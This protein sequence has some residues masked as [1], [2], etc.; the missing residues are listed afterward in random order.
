MTYRKVFR[1]PKMAKG[2]RVLIEFE[3]A[4][5]AAEVFVN[6]RSVVLSEDG[7]TAFGADI[8]SFLVEGQNTIEV[9]TDNDWGYRQRSTNSHY[10][11]NNKNFNVNYGG[12]T[13]NVR[14][15]I[16]PAVHQTLPL[17]SSMHTTGQYIYATNFDMARHAA[18][19]HAETQVVNTSEQSV[20]THLSVAIEDRDGNI[21]ARFEGSETTIPAG[22]TV[23]L[24]ASKRVGDLHFWSWGYGY[25]YKVRT[26]VGTDEVTTVTGFRQTA[27]EQGAV[28]LN[29][30]AIHMHGY[31]QRSTNEWP[32]VGNCVPAW[33]A[34]YGNQLCVD[35]GGNLVRWMHITPSKQEIESCDRVGL[36]QAMPAGDAEADVSD[37]RW[38]HRVE[39]MRDAIIY[40]RNNPSILFYEC[41]NKGI[42]REHYLEM[43]AL[44]DEFDPHGGR[45][46]GSREM[47][48]I[49]E[50]E[51]GGEM[52]YVNKSA[53]R[54]MWMME[55]CRDEGY[56]KYW[57]SWSY[58]FHPQGQGPL[59]RNAPAD[60]YNHNSDELAVELVRRWYDYWLERPGTSSTVCAGGAKIIFADTQTHCRGEMNYRTSGVVDAM[61]IPKDAFFTHQVMWDGWVDDLRPHVYIMGHWNYQEGEKLPTVYVV[62]NEGEPNLLINGT[63]VDVNPEPLYHFLYAYR[64]LPYQAGRIEARTAHA[65]YAIE[66]TGEPAALRLTPI[67]NPAGW[68]A[69]AADVAL[70][71]YE[72]V[73][74]QG[75]RCPLDDRAV[76]FSLQGPAEW[77]GGIAQRQMW[78]PGDGPQHQSD[79][80]AFSTTLPVEAGVNRVMLRSMRAAGPIMLTAKADGLSEATLTL[81]TVPFKSTD[82]L[83]LQMPTDGVAGNL[84][85]GETPSTPSFTQSGRDISIKSAIAG[86]RNETIVYTYDGNE[87]TT[88][89]SDG[90]LENAW[91]T[92]RLA[93][94]RPVAELVM[95]MGDWRNKSYPVEVVANGK[96]VWRGNTP[97]SL[98]YIHIPLSDVVADELTV[99][100]VGATYDGD[101]FGAVRELDS[102]NDD[103]TA[104]GGTILRIVEA[105]FVEHIKA[106]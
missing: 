28:W 44:R 77:R 81:H 40:N 43:K 55:Y 41:G 10:Q 15:H 25:L 22:Q 38:T 72:V 100:L 32:G 51:Y 89:A 29:G 19:I 1:L 54:P 7:I 106:I 67:V 50:S 11:W 6:G 45:A 57:N 82:G 90:K 65:S 83:S 35:G 52:L 74:A 16:V 8:T 24:S 39:V 47:L 58:P 60:A 87:R 18:D 85:R 5:Q 53:T 48:D 59:Y 49:F 26:T 37:I 14:L 23:S 101:A 34:D 4:K 71:E 92:F 79:N 70:V 84:S 46:I 98:S 94:K 62:S 91:I 12:L 68:K 20:K 95:K 21:V 102:K 97:K 69:D 9:H 103:K 3:G 76:T 93:E 78:K 73:D 99:R 63:P 2:D 105:Q 96:V 42:T 31:A 17:Y 61:R 86:C 66:T 104:R 80:M 88:W 30:R 56:R 75:R 13:K 33:L 64:N 27:Y 36:I